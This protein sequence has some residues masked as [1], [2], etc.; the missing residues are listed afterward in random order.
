MERRIAPLQGDVNEEELATLKEQVAAKT[1]ELEMQTGIEK[2]LSNQLVQVQTD[3]L[4]CQRSIASLK[5]EYDAVEC[6]MSTD[7]LYVDQTQKA[8]KL[9]EKEKNDMLVEEN[10]LRLQLT[11]LTR[12][13]DCHNEQV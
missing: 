2:T 10:M 9:A 6:R 7:E 12:I 5:N 11:R 3:V 4:Y 1:K 13:L 8:L